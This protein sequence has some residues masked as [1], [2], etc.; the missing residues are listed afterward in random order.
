MNYLF[1][2]KKLFVSLLSNNDRIVLKMYFY[3]SGVC[4]LMYGEMIAW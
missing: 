2:I 4:Y 3:M 1:E